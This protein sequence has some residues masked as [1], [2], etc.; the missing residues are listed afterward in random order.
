MPL[1]IAFSLLFFAFGS[2]AAAIGSVLAAFALASFIVRFGLT[3]VVA[4]FGED[5]VLSYAFFFGAAGFALVPL[6]HSTIA[7]AL[8]AFIFGL[9]M[10]C[11][12]PIT[13]MLMFSRSAEGRSGEMLGMRL[14]A[15]T[16]MR[17]AGPAVFGSLA[18]GFGLVAVLGLNALMM[19]VGGYVARPRRTSSKP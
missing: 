19:A 15:N 11:G 1:R 18:S 17:V 16:L 13:T 14:T 12:Q 8:T 5:R 3:R 6:C 7:L 4:R 9:G 10:G 2:V